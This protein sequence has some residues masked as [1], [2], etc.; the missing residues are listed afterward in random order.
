MELKG[1][2]RIDAPRDRVWAALNDADIL[3]RS[4]D[5]VERLEPVGENRFEGALKAKVGPVR[6]TFAGTVELT[7]VDPPNGYTLSGEGKGGVAGFAR[8]SADVALTDTGDG[9]T[10]LTYVATSQVGGKLAQLGS[11]LVEGAAKG[12]AE[13]FFRNFRAIVEG[14]PAP[15]GDVETP[16]PQL[17]PRAAKPPVDVDAAKPPVDVEAAK[18]KVDVEAALA[19]EARTGGIPPLVWASVLA[20]VVI[21]LLVFLLRV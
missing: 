14:P 3:A 5:G 20:I 4:I 11:R 12:Y 16:Q 9:A 2:V 17:D 13:S 7:N 21:L 18:P 8:G 6:A 15:P 19:D 1:E 10:M